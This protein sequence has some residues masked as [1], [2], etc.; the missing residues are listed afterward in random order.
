MAPSM[1]GGSL[2]M[3]VRI[4]LLQTFAFIASALAR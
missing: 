4:V 1:C 2:M 3:E